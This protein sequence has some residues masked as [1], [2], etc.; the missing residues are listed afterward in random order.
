MNSLSRSLLILAIVLSLSNAYH[1]Y[2]YESYVILGPEEFE[3][4]EGS[5]KINIFGPNN[6]VG[7][8]RLAD[9]A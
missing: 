6:T 5:L 4:L 3:P 8:F 1:A 2:E 7:T 9:K